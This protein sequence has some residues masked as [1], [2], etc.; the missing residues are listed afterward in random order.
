MNPASHLAQRTSASKYTLKDRSVFQLA[1]RSF[2][3]GWPENTFIEIGPKSQGDAGE[4]LSLLRERPGCP[5]REV[6]DSPG[7]VL[8][9]WGWA[10]PQLLAASQQAERAGKTRRLLQRMLSLC[11]LL[12]PLVSSP[13]VLWGVW[14]GHIA[15]LALLTTAGWLCSCPAGSRG[16]MSAKVR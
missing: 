2:A 9:R 14:G 7:R 15:H 1:P 10:E 4:S 11:W 16:G 5:G 8:R 13:V 3:G 6:Q 12:L